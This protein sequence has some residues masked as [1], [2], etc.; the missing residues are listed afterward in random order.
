MYPDTFILS[1]DLREEISRITDLCTQRHYIL[2]NE[3]FKNIINFSLR[4][5][6]TSGDVPGLSS[7]VDTFVSTVLCFVETNFIVPGV[8]NS[9]TYAILSELEELLTREIDIFNTNF[10]NILQHK[11]NLISVDNFGFIVTDFDFQILDVFSYGSCNIKVS[12]KNKR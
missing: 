10:L 4:I 1:F 3:D 7:R 5:I 11:L 9:T 6:N 2:N 12:R 8:D